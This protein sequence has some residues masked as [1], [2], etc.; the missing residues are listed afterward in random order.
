MRVVTLPDGED[1]DSFV[2]TRGPEALER[3]IGAA[4]DVFERKIQLLQRG[5]WFSELHRRRRA[6]DR[7]LPTIRAAA[8]PVTRDMYVGRAADAA[9]VDRQVLAGEVGEVTPPDRSLAV[10]PMQQQRSSESRGRR[11][12]ARPAAPAR[13]AGSAAEREL[14]RVMLVVTNDCGAHRRAGRACGIPGA[15]IPGDLRFADASGARRDL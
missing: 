15:R 9:G 7:M 14:I 12:G 11:L 8:D 5:G 13:T 2:R 1:P 10:E 6:I 3:Q 4:M